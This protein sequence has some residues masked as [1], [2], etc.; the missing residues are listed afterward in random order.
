M[1]MGKFDPKKAREDG[2]QG[3]PPSDYLLAVL[4]FERKMSKKDKPYLKCKIGI[5]AGAAKGKSFRDIISLDTSNEGTA[6]RL[7]L[8]LE[9]CGHE[10]EIDLDDD[11]AIAVAILKKPFKARVNRKHEN[12]YVNNG[13]ERYLVGK[14]VTDR[15]REVMTEWAI[16]KGAEADFEGESSY[17][18]SDA[19]PPGDDDIPF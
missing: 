3:V 14:D 9:S 12:G 16:E 1:I 7:A 6:F 4:N 10:G 19:P 13:I 17:D 8:L 2:N 15:D 11:K 18:D 5:I